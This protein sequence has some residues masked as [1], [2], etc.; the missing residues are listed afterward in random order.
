MIKNSQKQTGSA[1][2]VAI[3][4]L[5][6]ALIGAL[7]FIFWQNHINKTTNTPVAPNTTN[8]TTPDPYKDWAT[9]ESPISKY[10]IKYP[11][12]WLALK[13]TV[14]DGP[15]IR[16]F[17]PTSNQPQ[18]GYPD[19]YINLRVLVDENNANFKAM[20]GYTT[21]DWFEALGKAQVQSGPI[22]YLPED[23]KGMKISGLPAK[24]AK[25]VF[26]ETDEVIYV[27]RGD[28]LY[29]I[30]LYPYGISS[31]PTVKLMLESFTFTY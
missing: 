7:G 10:K 16:N 1:L 17:D 22:T 28:R 23:V 11:K 24:S 25:A 3:I 15:Y 31:D 2:V 21:T 27:L 29:S 18:G 9:Y 13:E 14:Q 19:G 6:V 8:S 26:T 20:T 5:V 12:D 30:N 4:I